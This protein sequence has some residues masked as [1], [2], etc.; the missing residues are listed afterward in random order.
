[1]KWT[2]KSA[3]AI[4][5]LLFV[6]VYPSFSQ[7]ISQP[8]K[9]LSKAEVLP[10]VD[11]IAAKCAKG[12]G[13]KEA[14]AKLSTQVM[15]G[16]IEISGP[17]ITGKIEITSKAPDKVFHMLSLA[18]GQFVQRRGF[19]GRAGWEI[20]SQK[21]L[22]RLE[23]AELEDAR[24]EG[25]FDTEIRLKEV[26][27][28]MKVTGRA[29]VGDRDAYTILIHTP[30]GKTN[31]FYFDAETGLRIAEDSEG[32]D[33][34][35]KIEKTNTLFEDYRAVSG[36]QIPFRIR[37][38][39]PSFSFVVHIQE[40]KHNVPIDDSI[41]AMP[42]TNTPG[43]NRTPEVNKSQ[44]DNEP[45]DPGTFSQDV[46]INRFFGIRYQAPSG[47]TAHGDE[48]KKEIMAVGKSL[49]DQ[50][51]ATGKA[52]ADRAGERTHQLLTLFEYPLGTPG[53]ENQLVQILAE[54]IR[55]APGVRSGKEYLLNVVRV[56][57]SM[58]TAPEMDEEPKEVT[59]G[60]KI[61]YR[62]DIVTKASAKTVYQSMIASVLKGYAVSFAF[63]SYSPEGRDKLVKTLESLR[64]DN[65]EEAAKPQ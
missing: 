55:F 10:S 21:G 31:T 50:K 61:L 47:W 5:A 42:S 7:A 37:I 48:T 52:I 57:K 19:D 45:L 49:M 40:V 17:G 14:W 30:G 46:Y 6:N 62:L 24:L 65:A 58:K 26:Y 33:A 1:M 38:T 13:G 41:F 27:P 22:K 60:G 28:D 2:L 51:S 56:L 54:D 64:L 4:L 23:G 12:S 25:V 36:I 44:D 9:E 63:T 11:E 35:G 18:E 32:A 29:K 53:V 8:K 20:D 16:T 39:S 3:A 15:G 59:Y 43:T 34:S